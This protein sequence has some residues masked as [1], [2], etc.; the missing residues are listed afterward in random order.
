MTAHS[1]PRSVLD[2]VELRC[3]LGQGD[4]QAVN[5]TRKFFEPLFAALVSKVTDWISSVGPRDGV[6]RWGT[7]FGD[8]QERAAHLATMALRENWTKKQK[9]DLYQPL[10]DLLVR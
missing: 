1:I 8:V 10:R 2:Q 9:Y 3:H 7:L 5:E 6:I 4:C